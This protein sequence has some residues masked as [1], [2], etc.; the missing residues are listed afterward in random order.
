MR[1]SRGVSLRYE[2]WRVSSLQ[3]WHPWAQQQIRKTPDDGP[4]GC[5]RLQPTT[6]HIAGKGAA[7]TKAISSVRRCS[8]LSDFSRIACASMQATATPERGGGGGSP[9]RHDSRTRKRCSSDSI[10]L[11]VV[12]QI[13]L[14]SISLM[15]KFFS[16][17]ICRRCDSDIS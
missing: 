2:T 13:C 14:P 7:V 12:L 6:T 11:V 15:A 9:D 16:L 8:P 3:T 17:Q 4:I 1:L 5:G 10:R